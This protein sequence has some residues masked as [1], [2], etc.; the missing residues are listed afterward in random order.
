MAVWLV[1]QLVRWEGGGGGGGQRGIQN[2]NV[3]HIESAAV[4]HHPCVNRAAFFGR[5]NCLL[6]FFFC[7][8]VCPKLS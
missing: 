5:V 1:E 8:C 6:S 7:V 2:Q 4:F 3:L